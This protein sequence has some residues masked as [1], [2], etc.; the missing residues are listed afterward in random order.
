M[1]FKD[2]GSSE[3]IQKILAVGAKGLW[4]QADDGGLRLLKPATGRLLVEP[5]VRRRDMEVWD[6]D[7]VTGDLVYLRGGEIWRLPHGEKE[8][9][10]VGAA[11]GP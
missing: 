3:T 11:G 1:S 4:L 8:P 10:R 6:L 5:N 2:L 7:P 9:E